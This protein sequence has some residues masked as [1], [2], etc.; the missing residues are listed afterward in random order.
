MGR[1]VNV[2]LVLDGS[3]GLAHFCVSAFDRRA[4]RNISRLLQQKLCYVVSLATRN[5]DP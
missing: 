1:C 4:M 3:G 2:F 5:E